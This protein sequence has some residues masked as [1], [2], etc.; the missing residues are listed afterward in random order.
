MSQKINFVDYSVAPKVSVMIWQY[1][2]NAN[3]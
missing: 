3:Y 2:Y 1:N